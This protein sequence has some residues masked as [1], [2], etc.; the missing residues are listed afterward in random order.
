MSEIICAHCGESMTMAESLYY[1]HDTTGK[2]YCLK[3]NK[4][5]TNA[6]EIHE[7]PEQERPRQDQGD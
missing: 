4:D 1:V 5:E 7:G 6:T 3:A 2:T